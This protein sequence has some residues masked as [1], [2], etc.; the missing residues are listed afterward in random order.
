MSVVLHTVTGAN[1]AGQETHSNSALHTER[2]V[3][4][5]ANTTTLRLNVGSHKDDTCLAAQD[6]VQGH[7]GCN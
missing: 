7:Q 3:G 2:D 5:V 1:I 4:N 6:A